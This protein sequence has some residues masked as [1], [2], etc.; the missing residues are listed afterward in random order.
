M[1][2]MNTTRLI[3][4]KTVYFKEEQG[5][6]EIPSL[7]FTHL[8]LSALKTNFIHPLEYCNLKGGHF[9]RRNWPLSCSLRLPTV[10]TSSYGFLSLGGSF[11]TH[12][13]N[14]G[15]A[16]I[17][18]RPSTSFLGAQMTQMEMT[19][20]LASGTI[21]AQEHPANADL[22]AKTKRY[23]ENEKFV[24]R[25]F[26]PEIFECLENLGLENPLNNV[27]LN[28]ILSAHFYSPHSMGETN[29]TT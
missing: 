22:E 10:L 13:S 26:V 9:A 24:P 29:T 25:K 1:V 19:L 16:N 4:C 15:L 21:P 28:K 11:F 7:T 20:L 17:L 2:K 8:F 12:I 6:K 27:P 3:A 18:N 23:S 5:G 14:L